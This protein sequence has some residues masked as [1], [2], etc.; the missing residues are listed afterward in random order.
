MRAEAYVHPAIG[1]KVFGVLDKRQ[2]GQ[3]HGTD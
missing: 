1:N 3:R 2:E